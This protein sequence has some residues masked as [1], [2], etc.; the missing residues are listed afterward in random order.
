MN[1][2]PFKRRE[3]AGQGGPAKSSHH[4]QF[5]EGIISDAD[6]TVCAAKAAT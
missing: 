3:P 5:N 2:Q 4:Q 1:S 6:P